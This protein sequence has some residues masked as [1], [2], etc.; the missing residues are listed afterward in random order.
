VDVIEYF[1]A[2]K[3]APPLQTSQIEAVVGELKFKIQYYQTS[4]HESIQKEKP[5]AKKVVAEKQVLKEN[6]FPTL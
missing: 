6:D 5:T 1:D 2:V 3:I 4:E